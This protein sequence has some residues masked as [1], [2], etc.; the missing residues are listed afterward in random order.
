M[1]WL[2]FTQVKMKRE[3]RENEA[4]DVS[5]FFPSLLWRN[6]LITWMNWLGGGQLQ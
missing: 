2:T 3:K 6:V 5:V 1:T 4:A